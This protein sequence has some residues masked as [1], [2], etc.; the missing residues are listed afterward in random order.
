[1]VEGTSN[2]HHLIPSMFGGKEKVELHI[3][4]HDKLHHTFTEREML[5]YYNTIE[6]ILE[7]EDIQKFV[8]W[9]QKK[10][11]NYYSK[12]KDTNKRKGKR[13]R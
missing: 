9:I 8:K 2:D 11:V 12:N 4:C 6:R 13:R 7:N 3:I 10:D 5:N 1:M